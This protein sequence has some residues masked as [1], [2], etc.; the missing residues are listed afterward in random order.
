VL[1]VDW[2]GRPRCLQRAPRSA[3]WWASSTIGKSTMPRYLGHTLGLI[4]SEKAGAAEP[5]RRRSQ[6]APA[7]G[8]GCRP[9]Q[10]AGPGSPWGVPCSGWIRLRSAVMSF[11]RRNF[12]HWR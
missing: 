6:R 11:V 1:E 12:L 2:E 7:P 3:R 9:C 10:A 5:R 8:G 4:A